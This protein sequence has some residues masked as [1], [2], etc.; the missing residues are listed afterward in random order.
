M[1]S[2]TPLPYKGLGWGKEPAAGTFPSWAT[3]TAELRI[4]DPCCG[5]GHFLTGAFDLLRRMR[6]EEDGLLAA[7]AADAVLR[8]NLFGLELD[9]RCTQVAMF[10]LSMAAW[11]VGGSPERPEHWPQIA[12]S[13]TPIRAD[14]REW[15]GLTSGRDAWDAEFLRDVYR[16]FV[17]APTLGSLIDLQRLID[18]NPYR[19]LP[20]NNRRLQVLLDRIL[21][22]VVAGDDHP[23]FAVNAG[24]VAHAYDILDQRYDLTVTN[25]PYLSRGAHDPALRAFADR[26]HPASKSDLATMMLER[27]VRFGATGGTVAAVTPQNWLFL[28]SYRRMRQDFLVA[29]SLDLVARLGTGAFETVSG[30]VVNVALVGISAESPS[31][32]Q[33]FLGIDASTGKEPSSKAILLRHGPIALASQGVQKSNEDYYI[34]FTNQNSVHTPLRLVATVYQGVST[35]DIHRFTLRFWEHSGFT[36]R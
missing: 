5:S 20:R 36:K 23:L 1:A 24:E 34:S 12:W 29:A 31:D 9:R 18:A 33:T 11:K 21:K 25:I 8:D 15:E 6:M 13:G 19:M 27:C 30:E 35:T 7:E 10:N 2:A 4:L 26:W 22:Q 3:T 32:T 16:V 17:D 28:G 14:A